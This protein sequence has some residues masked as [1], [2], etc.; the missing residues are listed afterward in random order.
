MLFATSKG[1][2]VFPSFDKMRLKDELVQGIYAFGTRT[3]AVVYTHLYTHSTP[4]LFAC[5][6]L[7]P[8]T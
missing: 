5:T 7:E 4:S 3:A 8:Q 2:K 6:L 1:V